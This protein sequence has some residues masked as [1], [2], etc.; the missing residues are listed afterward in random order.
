V[1][2]DAGYLSQMLTNLVGNAIKYSRTEG[3]QVMLETG[4]QNWQGRPFSWIRVIDNGPGIA[5]EHQKQLFDRFFRVDS[6]R[7]S[8]DNAGERSDSGTGL[9]LSIVQSIVQAHGGTIDLN[10]QVGMGT[11]FIVWLPARKK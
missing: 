11:T 2:G 6:A 1:Y 7:R 8:E 10:S 9:G 3:A 4:S 5:P